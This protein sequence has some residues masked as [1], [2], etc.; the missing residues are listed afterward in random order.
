MAYTLPRVDVCFVCL[1]G[2]PHTPPPCTVCGRTGFFHHQGL[3]TGCHPYSPERRDACPDCYAWGTS[4]VSRWRCWG[5]LG[6]HRKFSKLGPGGP[7]GWCG[8]TVAL[9]RDHACR[10][11]WQQRARLRRT[12]GDL[13]LSYAT[14]LE[15]G[16]IQLSFA[17]T[18]PQERRP[19]RPAP[20][21]SKA[22]P[23]QPPAPPAAALGLAGAPPAS[24]AARPTP[25]ASA[26]PPAP[27]VPFTHRQLTLFEPAPRQMSAAPAI[28]RD[29]VLAAWLQEEL[30]LW[31]SSRGWSKSHFSRARR[32][33]HIVLSLQDTPGAPVP[34]TLIHQL[35]PL[36]LPARLIEEFLRVR[37]FTEDDHTLAVDAWFAR[38]TAHLP[39]PMSGQLALWFTVRLH[40]HP[41]P[42]RSR[43][44]SAITVR[45]QLLFALPVLTR[46]AGAGTHNLA[47][48]EAAHLDT[49]LAACGLTGTPYSHT[50]AGLRSLFATLHAHRVI[51]SN[52]AVGLRV[53][54]PA[55]TIPLPADV[56]PIREALTSPD[57]TRAAVTALLAFHALRSSEIRH[58]ML[59]E[60]RQLDEGRLLLPDRTVLV[61]EPVRARLAAYLAH[62]HRRWP[63][64]ANPYFLVNFR[65]ALSTR[66]V[67]RPWLWRQYPSSS[68]LLRDDRIVDEVQ[69][70]TDPRTLCELFGLTYNAV[71]RYT[72]PYQDAAHPSRTPPAP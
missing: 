50:A 16:C 63:H 40:G 57:P 6:W 8:R 35:T 17:N 5:C 38:T 68:L 21:T 65:T 15:S 24:A 70:D 58:L 7:C 4:A 20:R 52:P 72:W 53:R 48:V 51:P 37:G 61:A 28:P 59:D 11:C 41:R 22:G 29:P 26:V 34:T 56:L 19:A 69:A 67:S 33:L 66:P 31:A 2:G 55:R 71:T 3:C 64:T 39:D 43:P 32:G 42:P 46:L 62:R 47:D 36:G 60:A 14:A 30:A 12:T 9:N 10:M 27:V 25:L 13:R 54:T 23:L 44:R 18:R 1:P 45:H 49:H